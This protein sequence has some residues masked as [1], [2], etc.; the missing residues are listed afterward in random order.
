VRGPRTGGLRT[1][2]I[3]LRPFRALT[4]PGI[5]EYEN[6]PRYEDTTSYRKKKYS[7]Y[8]FGVLFVGGI[9]LAAANHYRKDGTDGTR[10]QLPIRIRRLVGQYLRGL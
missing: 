1:P 2:A 10:K 8:A 7:R 3:D 9:W 5:I 4:S 6:S